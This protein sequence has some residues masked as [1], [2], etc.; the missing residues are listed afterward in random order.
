MSAALRLVPPAS[1]V[2]PSSTCPTLVP[3]NDSC[4][5]PTAVRASQPPATQRSPSTPHVPSETRSE[6]QTM[7]AVMRLNADFLRFILSATSLPH[8]HA[9]DAIDD[10]ERGIETLEHHFTAVPR[11]R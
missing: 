2:S 6:A 3:A 10:L 1:D 4:A 5:V 8:A 9:R 11:A 7:L